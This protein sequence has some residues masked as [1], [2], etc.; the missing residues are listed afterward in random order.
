MEVRGSRNIGVSAF[1]GL[2]GECGYCE[3]RDW[4]FIYFHT[5]TMSLTEF[6]VPVILSI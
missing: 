2:G 3:L 4:L 6:D 1:Y 5:H